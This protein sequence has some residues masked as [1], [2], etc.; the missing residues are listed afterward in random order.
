MNYYSTP[1]RNNP[2]VNSNSLL[3]NGGPSIDNRFLMS[4]RTNFLQQKLYQTDSTNHEFPINSQPILLSSNYEKYNVSTIF[5][6]IRFIFEYFPSIPHVLSLIVGP[7]V[8]VILGYAFY[9]TVIYYLQNYDQQN[10]EG[11]EI[12]IVDKQQQ[13]VTS[14]SKNKMED[15]TEE[16][17][18]KYQ[19]IVNRILKSNRKQNSSTTSISASHYREKQMSSPLFS[20]EDLVKYLLAHNNKAAV[21]RLLMIKKRQQQMTSGDNISGDDIFS[22]KKSNRDFLKSLHLK[23]FQNLYHNPSSIWATAT[24]SGALASKD[25]FHDENSI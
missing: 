14:E 17:D 7:I 19:E 24:L 5:S 16:Q 21:R 23:L 18:Q 6:V 15:I 3:D 22:S 13:Q 12:I 10:N 9:S 25:D 2:Y 1:I 4:R 8:M 11:N 20:S